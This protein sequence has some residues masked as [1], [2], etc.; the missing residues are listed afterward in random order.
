MGRQVGPEQ[1]RADAADLFRVHPKNMDILIGRWPPELGAHE[2]KWP[3]SF[4]VLKPVLVRG[5]GWN[6]QEAPVLESY[7]LKEFD[8]EICIEV[9]P[10]GDNQQLEVGAFGLNTPY[11]HWR[12]KIAEGVYWYSTLKPD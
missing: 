4:D 7:L 12:E 10:T 5:I 3:K 8:S 9:V 2:P 6:S 11:P 1:L